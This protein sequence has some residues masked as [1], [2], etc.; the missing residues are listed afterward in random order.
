MDSAAGATKLTQTCKSAVIL[1]GHVNYS[2][3]ISCRCAGCSGGFLGPACGSGVGS[4]GA[5][6][7]LLTLD[8]RS[9]RIDD[10]RST[11]GI[12]ENV[13]RTA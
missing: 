1:A 10:R 7:Q 9:G 2:T 13:W 11:S 12:I 5:L 8:K 6:R 4:Q 3:T